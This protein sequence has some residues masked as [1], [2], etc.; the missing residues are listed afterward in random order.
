MQI[1]GVVILQQP[2]PDFFIGTDDVIGKPVDIIPED[3]HQSCIQRLTPA[4]VYGG[5]DVLRIEMKCCGTGFA[6]LLCNPCGFGRNKKGIFKVNDISPADGFF[7]HC[8]ICLC[9]AEALPLDQRIEN[10]HPEFRQREFRP[11]ADGIRQNG[12]LLSLCGQLGTETL[13][14]DAHTVIHCKILIHHQ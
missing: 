2:S 12:N 5:K 11:A 4:K 8:G 6:Q 7:N 13:C 14:G 10:G 1:R 3:P 9:K